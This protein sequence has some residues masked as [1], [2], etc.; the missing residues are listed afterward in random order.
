MLQSEVGHVDFMFVA[1]FALQSGQRG[2]DL[3]ILDDRRAQR[4]DP[5][6]LVEVGKGGVR[7]VS[8]GGS[9][10]RTRDHARNAPQQVRLRH[11]DAGAQHQ[12]QPKKQQG[13]HSRAA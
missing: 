11:D 6:A 2:V 12:E 4:G 9:G 3:L 8:V 7:R 5:I 10:P 1:R 13:H